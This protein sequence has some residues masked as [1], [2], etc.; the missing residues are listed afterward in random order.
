MNKVLYADDNRTIR[1]LMEKNLQQLGY[2][3]MMLEDGDQ[4]DRL[5][6]SGEYPQ[7]IILDW[8]MPGK[9]GPELCSKIKELQ[10]KH[11]RYNYVMLCTTRDT[12]EDIVTGFSQG[13]DDYISKPFDIRQLKARIEVGFRTLTYQK[14]IEAKEFRIRVN[15]YKALTELAETHCM[16]TASHLMHIARLSE[17]LARWKGCNEDFIRDIELFSPMHDIGK[18]GI[19][20][21]LLYLPRELT[22]E[23]FQLVKNHTL[24]GW[25]ILK[26]KETLEMAASIALTH[27]EKWNGSGYPQGL[28]GKNIPLCGRITA[29]CDVYDTLRSKRTYKKNWNHQESLNFLISERGRAFD[30]ELIE[31]LEVHHEEWAS[32]YKDVSREKVSLEDIT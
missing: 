7:L 24:K 26:D 27:H 11:K 1:L 31:I 30:P 23:E 32:M 4:V 9:T 12:T 6:D 13:A 16:E 22:P 19:P 18:V 2:E 20:E 21:S 25:N 5:L 10:K 28:Q 8:E 14:E 3:Y 17:N 15:C 29:I